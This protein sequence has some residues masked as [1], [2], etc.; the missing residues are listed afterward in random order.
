MNATREVSQNRPNNKQSYSNNVLSEG[1]REQPRVSS[2][3]TVALSTS[4]ARMAAA[5]RVVTYEQ[6]LDT[7]PEY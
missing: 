5:S 2:K 3:H 1:E 7:D 6:Q 4:T